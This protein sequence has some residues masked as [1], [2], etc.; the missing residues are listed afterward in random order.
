[1]KTLSVFTSEENFTKLKYLDL[2]NNKFTDL[3]NFALP[4]LEYLDISHNKLEKVNENWKGH[5]KLR[6]LN[7][8]DNKF[9]SLVPF[10]DCPK[11]EELY[12][13]NN[14]IASITGLDG[15]PSLKKL[16][17]RHNK[18]EKIEEEL[19]PL[20][21]LEYL[22]LRTNKIPDL[23]NLFRLFQYPNLIRINVLNCPVELG[24]SSMNMFIAEVLVKR[25]TIKRFCKVD[26]N[27]NHKLE[28]VYLAK[29][30]W[31]VE[32]EKRKKKEAAEAEA[33]RKR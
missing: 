17:L 2:A 12:L 19:V 9:K 24:Y 1:M 28:S 5:P 15:V 30:K 20:E 33:E 10:K 26:I 11:L 3:T 27:D 4:S 32:E 23:E 16:N 21:A 7:A 14:A 29:Y 8:A 18:I 25:T 22:N 13:Q 6:Y 31:E